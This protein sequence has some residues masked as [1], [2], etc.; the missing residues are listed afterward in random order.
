MQ[1][2]MSNNAT[3]YRQI[4]CRR[5]KRLRD[6]TDTETEGEKNVER[7]ER[8]QPGCRQY[9]KTEKQNRQKNIST[10]S[11]GET[12]KEQKK[13]KKRERYMFI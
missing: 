4:C 2:Q 11:D 12:D 6:K 7:T 1:A 10:K 8:K 9:I 3:V 13:K 5:R